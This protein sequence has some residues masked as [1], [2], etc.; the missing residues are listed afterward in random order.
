[1]NIAE[2]LSQIENN[3]LVL[4]K[5]F[6]L[7]NVD[8][9]IQNYTENDWFVFSGII[10]YFEKPLSIKD[11]NHLKKLAKN[12]KNNLSPLTEKAKQKKRSCCL[13]SSL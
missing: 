9:I 4:I 1:M 2:N 11:K 12:S 13:D 5:Q 7:P 3:Y 10:F 8:F 6:N